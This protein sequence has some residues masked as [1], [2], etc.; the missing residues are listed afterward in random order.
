M[1]FVWGCLSC[2]CRL[3]ANPHGDKRTITYNDYQKGDRDYAEAA[4]YNKGSA[5][6][7][8]RYTQETL[9]AIK[10]GKLSPTKR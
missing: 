3:P 7:A 4:K 8:K 5:A 6:E 2:G 1:L 9:G 10:K